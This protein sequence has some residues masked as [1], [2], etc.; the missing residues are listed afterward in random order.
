MKNFTLLVTLLLAFTVNSYSQTFGTAPNCSLPAGYILSQGDRVTTYNNP[1]DNCKEHCGIVTPGVGGNNPGNIVFPP[2]QPQGATMSVCFNLWAFDANLR[3]ESHK[4]LKCATTVDLYIVAA[5]YN[6][7]QAPSPSEYYGKNTI[8]IHAE[9]A[10]N[11]GTIAFQKPY[12]PSQQYRVFLDFGKGTTCVQQD[13]KYVI[14]IT[15][16]GG[17]MPITLSAF[18]IDRNGS[19]INLNW[20][21]ENETNAG[22]FEIQR[23]FDNSN[24]QTIG[25]LA[26]HVNSNTTQSYSYVDRTNTSKTVSFY[27]LKILKLNGEV[28]YSDIKA[29]KSFSGKSDFILFPNPSFGKA[30]ITITD[31]NEPTNVQLLDNSG[32][33][34]KSI[35][36]NNSNSV[37]INGL[38]KGAYIV[39]ITGTV[40]GESTARKLTVIN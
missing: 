11:C 26:S 1:A 24:F 37:E 7:V 14:D 15:P 10:Q 32:R 34:V 25:T 8:P 27:R 13:T 2:T 28:S 31:L 35:L 22:N 19:S 4:E 38:Q 20:K 18:L 23:S 5:S 16:Q 36:L 39:R 21:T 17:P 33:L 29:V 6:S 9:G 30:K 12:D 3:C 40:S